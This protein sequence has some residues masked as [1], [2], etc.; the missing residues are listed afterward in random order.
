MFRLVT[1]LLTVAAVAGPALAQSPPVSLASSIIAI[2]RGDVIGLGKG[3]TA[4]LGG[5]SVQVTVQETPAEIRIQLPA[6]ILFDFDKAVLRASARQ[7]LEQAAEVVRK[8]AGASVR[9]E[10]HTDSKGREPYN[11]KLSLKRSEAVRGYLVQAIGP[12][13]KRADVIG[14]AAKRPVAPNTKPDGSDDP[15]GRQLNRRVEVILTK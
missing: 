14:F 11:L 15:D 12:D 2:G 13:L 5:G 4:P 3:E 7:A 6:D 8:H 1:L 10:G 9:I